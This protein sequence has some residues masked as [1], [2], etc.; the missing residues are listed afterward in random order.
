MSS[1]TAEDMHNKYWLM[2]SADEM[3]KQE[4]I[5]IK[6]LK[7]SHNLFAVTSIFLVRS[8]LIIKYCKVFVIFLEQY[9]IYTSAP[10]CHA[11]KKGQS[12]FWQI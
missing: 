11:F 2:T 7:L 1:V 3:S 5:S 10:V 8:K 6:Q 12:Y 9:L 4:I